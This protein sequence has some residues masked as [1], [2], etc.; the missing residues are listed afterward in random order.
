MHFDVYHHNVCVVEIG[1]V[2]IFGRISCGLN[3]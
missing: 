3:G 1:M 2:Y